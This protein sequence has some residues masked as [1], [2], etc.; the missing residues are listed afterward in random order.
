MK[1]FLMITYHFP[2]AGG[3]STPASIRMGKFAKYLP[4]LGWSP[5]I[6]S[7]PPNKNAII[8]DGLVFSETTNFTLVRDPIPIFK[9]RVRISSY[10]PTPGLEV[11]WIYSVIKNSL[12]KIRKNKPS[13]IFVSSPPISV[14]FAGYILHKITKLPLVLDYR[15][16]WIK[17]PYYRRKKIYANWDQFLEK[18]IIK[19]STA[20]IFSNERILKEYREIYF[21][22]ERKLFVVMNGFDKEDFFDI[23]P[24]RC[25]FGNYPNELIIRHLGQIYG[26]RVQ[27]FVNFIDGLKKFLE[28]S[29]NIPL[30]KI[31]LFGFHNEIISKL[32]NI[33]QERLSIEFSKNVKYKDALSLELGSDLLLLIIGGNNNNE[34]ELT[35]KIFEYLQSE[36]PLLILGESVILKEFLKGIKNVFWFCPHPSSVEYK[37]FIEWSKKISKPN[38]VKLRNS[39]FAGAFSR[40]ASAIHL[41]EIFNN[42]LG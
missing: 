25:P 12:K 39:Q 7:A 23:L 17:S 42:V 14:L 35:S 18:K 41:A 15:D 27:V 20:I 2:P 40:K 36:R 29:N 8:D 6:I 19:K 24:D 30:I 13:L 5:I 31:Q 1:N 21:N 22:Y 9:G 11:F 38:R 4:G 26:N 32:N 37:A 10:L 28:E 3:A 34:I 16:P 33:D